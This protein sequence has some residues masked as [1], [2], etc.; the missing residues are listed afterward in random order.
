MSTMATPEIMKL[1]IAV[2]EVWDKHIETHV[3]TDL[4]HYFPLGLT[5]TAHG[6]HIATL[7]EEGWD[8]TDPKE[9]KA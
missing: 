9:K 6:D 8:L 1:L 4:Q 3:S 7:Y 5:I 2:Q